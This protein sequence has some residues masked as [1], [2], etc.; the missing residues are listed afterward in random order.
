MKKVAL[1]FVL[2]VIAPSLVLAWLAVRSLSDQQFLLERQRSLLYQGVADSMAKSVLDVLAENQRQFSDKTA[3]LLRRRSAQQLS[4]TFDAQLRTEWPLAQVG[5]VVNVKGQLLCPS[6]QDRP[7]ARVFCVDNSRFL[8]NAEAAEVYWNPKSAN[9][10]LLANN[11]S[12]AGQNGQQQAAMP[13]QK[14]TLNELTSQG[15]QANQGY[16]NDDKKLAYANKLSSRN[17]IPQ[18]QSSGFQKPGYQQEDPPQQQVSKL[19]EAEAE[20][21]HLIR[22]D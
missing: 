4:K 17:V 16:L 11:N 12:N 5:F 9:Q 7:E 19:T 8:G 22:D 2:A 21:R 3:D 15:G 10:S 6:P 14:S 1:V 18:Q 20:F 13:V